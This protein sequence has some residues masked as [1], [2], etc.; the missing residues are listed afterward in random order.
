MNR[1]QENYIDDILDKIIEDAREWNDSGFPEYH[2]DDLKTEAMQEI[3]RILK[4]EP[5]IINYKDWR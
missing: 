4:N 1:I 5:T 2:P 3:K